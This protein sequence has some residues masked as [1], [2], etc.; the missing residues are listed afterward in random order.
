MSDL[1]DIG[2]RPPEMKSDDPRAYI[3]G[4]RRCAVGVC[5]WMGDAGAWWVGVSPRNGQHAS[6]EGSWE[7][8]VVM[9]RGILKAHAEAVAKGYCPDVPEEP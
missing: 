7:D 5:P 6:V 8:W 9:A 3:P 4:G 2:D 1:G